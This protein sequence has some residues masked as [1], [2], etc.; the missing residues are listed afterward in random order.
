MRPLTVQLIR[1]PEPAWELLSRLAAP[2]IFLSP[3]WL[4]SWW[5]CYGPRHQG[6][7]RVFA[8]LDAEGGLRGL[9]PMYLKGRSL[10]FLGDGSTDSDYL[11]FILERGWEEECLAAFLPAFLERNDEWNLLE[12]NEISHG[13]PA[14]P[15]LKRLL[16]GP[17][18]I[19]VWRRSPGRAVELSPTWKEK[20]RP[21]FRGS[22]RQAL[23]NLN[24]WPGGVEVL[25]RPEQL[26]SWLSEFF[27]MHNRR[28]QSRGLP[29]AFSSGERRR[30][31]AEMSRKF[32][33]RG[34]LH[35]SRWRTEGRTFAY[36]FGFVF[37][38]CYHLLQEGFDLDTAHLSPGVALR[39]ANFDEL[40][41]QGV[42][43][44]DFLA[45]AAR[46]K[47]DWAPQATWFHRVRC[48]PR[49]FS[50]RA[51]LAALEGF[52]QLRARL[53]RRLPSLEPWAAPLF[54]LGVTD[55]VRG[56]SRRLEFS[57]GKGLRISRGPKAV[58]LA[59][60]RVEPGGGHL[61]AAV[62]PE[63]FE[64]QVL[65]LKRNYPVVSMSELLSGSHRQ[66]VLLTFDD[67]YAG[68]YDH[69]FP[70]L[71]H[72]QVPALVYLI[73]DCVESGRPPWYERLF[74]LLKRAP[75]GPFELELDGRRR[76][77]LATSEDRLRLASKIVLH[78]RCWPDPRRREFCLALEERLGPAPHGANPMLT[79]AQILEMK[80][81]GI[82]FGGHTMSHPV[83]ARLHP[84]HYREE[85][86]ESK[87]LLEELLRL[88][89]QDFSF[90]FGRESECP[91][92]GDRLRA[93]GYRS[94]VTGNWGLNTTSTDPFRLKRVGLGDHGELPLF[95]HKLNRLF[96]CPE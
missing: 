17:R 34:W 73:A 12:L 30:F 74:E 33:A 7:L 31:Y 41:R 43:R 84:D 54:Q 85:L 10:R 94:A 76:F 16:D 88:E 24:A 29:G 13:S 53:P 14:L 57:P 59:Y 51:R 25:S 9:A 58:V 48:L 4:S 38:H 11:D 23:E 66:A 20:L 77:Q 47:R 6:R 18:W 21:R 55:L 44:Y 42:K 63:R 40:V 61:A 87:T 67:G 28:W 8:A 90:P 75:D 70:I 65:Y 60:H 79:P 27:Q 37:D 86:L 19:S 22:V 56:L 62:S 89:V 91:D 52:D 15:A 64:E 36:Q 50:G 46:H 93:Y 80:R 68:F 2:S 71:K 78:L 26:E 92:L 95:A 72:H 82:G 39:A 96:W 32:L 81:A 1:E 83:L 45:G 3:E 5:S 69:A 49:T 35:F